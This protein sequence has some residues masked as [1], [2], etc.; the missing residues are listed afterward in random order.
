MLLENIAH[1]MVDCIVQDHWPGPPSMVPTAWQ[2][3]CEVKVPRKTSY[4]M[5]LCLSN[6][7]RSGA[8]KTHKVW[9]PESGIVPPSTSMSM[10]CIA[11][12]PHG[13]SQSLPSVAANLPQKAGWLLL[14]LSTKA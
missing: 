6:K 7:L 3:S 5:K 12:L 4:M 13:P 1:S 2:L 11:R 8:P 10:Y 9:L 14:I